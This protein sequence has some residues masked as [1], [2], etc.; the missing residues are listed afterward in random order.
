MKDP[1][2]FPGDLFNGSFLCFFMAP[3]GTLVNDFYKSFTLY[4][5][6]ILEEIPCFLSGFSG[7]VQ[8]SSFNLI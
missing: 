4:S 5:D 2:K 7:F 8:G 1:G 3:A 6:R